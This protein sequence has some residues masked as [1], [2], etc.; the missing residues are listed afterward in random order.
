VNLVHKVKRIIEEQNLIEPGET[1]L[2]GLS[3]GIDS[4][5][6]LY[7]LLEVGKALSFKLGVAHINHLLRGEESLRD[8]EF[9]RNLARNLSLPCHI[10]RIDVRKEAKEAGKSLQHA[11]RDARYGFFRAIAAENNYQK[12]GVAHT[13]DDQVETFILRMLKGTG[14]KGLSAIPVKRDN[15]VR[16][17]LNITRAEI[18]EYAR[19]HTVAFVDDSSNEKVVYERNFIRKRIVPQMEELNPAFREKVFSLLKDI[20]VLNRTFDE[21]ADDFVKTRV[22]WDGG[23]A[24]LRVELLKKLD[25]ETRFRVFTRLLDRMEP[26]FIP[27]REH[28]R[29]IDN[30]LAGL[31][32]NLAVR[33]PHDFRVK[34]IYEKLVITKAAPAPAP[35]DVLPVSEGPNRLEPFKLLLGIEYFRE[36]DAE[37]QISTDPMTATFDGDKLGAL[38]IRF[39]REGDRFVPLGMSASVKL[40]DFFMSRKIPR[41]ERRHIPLL[42]SGDDIIWVVGH[43]I[44]DRFKATKGTGCKM[45]AHAELL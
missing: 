32:P 21:R 40:K 2:L 9:V 36:S 15:I 44:D 34:K 12:I 17:L 30:V 14:L 8:E 3:G 7:L 39:F 5:T 24:S 42:L 4:T 29:Q 22:L 10:V 11:G 18:E 38:K 23:T 26:G 20:T 27:L 25:E 31:R 6:M 41:E 13:L 28:M 45:K 43:R 1:V 16:P 33:L 35:E 19:V 37:G